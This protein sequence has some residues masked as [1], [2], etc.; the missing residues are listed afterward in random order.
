MDSSSAWFENIRNLNE[1]TAEYQIDGVNVPTIALIG[2]ENSGKTSFIEHFTR[3]PIGFVR[4]GEDSGTATRCPVHFELEHAEQ[5]SVTF[6]SNPHAEPESIEVDALSTRLQQHMQRLAGEGNG[7]NSQPCRVRMKGPKLVTFTFIDLP[8]MVVE[9]VQVITDMWREYLQRPNVCVVGMCNWRNDLNVILDQVVMENTINENLA[10]G[11]RVI[12]LVNKTDTYA[13]QDVVIRSLN[14]HVVNPQHRRRFYLLSLRPPPS[15]GEVIPQDESRQETI[16][17]AQEREEAFFDD[18]VARLT[19]KAEADAPGSYDE[20][21]FTSLREQCGMQ[22]VENLLTSQL[23]RMYHDTEGRIC[24]VLNQEINNQQEELTAVN[25][26]LVADQALQASEF[27]K[28]RV[29]DRWVKELFSVLNLNHVASR[30]YPVETFGKT[31]EDD[32]TFIRTNSGKSPFDPPR[33]VAVTDGGERQSWCGFDNYEDMKNSIGVGNNDNLQNFFEGFIGY[34]VLGNASLIRLKKTLEYLLLM[35]LS[36]EENNSR[37]TDEELTGLKVTTN[38]DKAVVDIVV[39]RHLED[40]VDGVEWLRAALEVKVKEF[41]EMVRN[42]LFPS[43]THDGE[44]ESF[45]PVATLEVIQS[46]I[47]QY[48]KENCFDKLAERWS[49]TLKMMTHPNCPVDNDMVIRSLL[50]VTYPGFNFNLKEGHFGSEFDANAGQRFKSMHNDLL[51]Y[52]QELNGLFDNGN[53][54]GGQVPLFT[55]A[56]LLETGHGTIRQAAPADFSVEYILSQARLY[57]CCLV[58]KIIADLDMAFHFYYM[59]TIKNNSEAAQAVWDIVRETRVVKRFCRRMQVT[60]E[61]LEERKET[62]ERAVEKLNSVY[63]SISTPGSREAPST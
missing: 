38:S 14:T 56:D 61:T 21:F 53:G 51:K 31:L 59:T 63:M 11:N 58:S 45:I 20:S 15:T 4:A 22:N 52:Q 40:C 10:E 35:K 27:L 6:Q 18:F 26:E 33:G 42:R 47:C 57:Y 16:N 2:A 36:P 50:Q 24:A 1:L 30:L 19:V 17:N 39:R 62:L 12:Y 5:A 41:C 44:T 8:G 7:F 49:A 37:F 54:N 3:V 34:R 23:K 55:C 48:F 32:L 29:I 13:I 9:Y 46:A 28:K 43:T 60:R 25:A